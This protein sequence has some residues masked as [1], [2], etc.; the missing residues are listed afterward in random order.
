MTE[1]KQYLSHCFLLSADDLRKLCELMISRINSVQNSTTQNIHLEVEFKDGYVQQFNSVDE[2]LQIENED[3]KKIELLNIEIC[4]NNSPVPSYKILIKFQDCSNYYS[5]IS[6]SYHIISEDP[7]WV[8][9]TESQIKQK[10][11]KIKIWRLKEFF[12]RGSSGFFAIVMSVL[13]LFIGFS[14]ILSNNTKESS[15]IKQSLESLELEYKNGK[16][17]DPVQAIILLEKLK[18][19]SNEQSIININY[20]WITGII[21]IIIGIV[22]SFYCFPAY[23]FYWG[24][25]IKEYRKK[26]SIGYT[27][28]VVVLLGIVISVFSNWLSKKIGI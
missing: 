14:N 6:I 18:L 12:D 13:V 21:L 24:D 19:K 9:L 3:S 2:V 8:F 7:N 16:I 4:D 1:V 26:T 25:Y 15:Q 5:D 11:S 28:L 10:L 23:N 27:I 20:G 22:A 17:K